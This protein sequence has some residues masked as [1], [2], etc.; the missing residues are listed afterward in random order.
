[1]VSTIT[2]AKNGT[3]RNEYHSMEC[4]WL[5]KYNK[6]KEFYN[7]HGHAKVFFSN[8][9]DESLA[10]WVCAQRR[11]CKTESRIELLNAIGFIWNSPEDR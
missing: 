6:L 2:G 7:A 10:H 3:E 4:K 8:F 1:M 5:E 9:E 11:C